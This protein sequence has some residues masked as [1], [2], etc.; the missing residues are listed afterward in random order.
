MKFESKYALGALVYLR[1]GDNR[2]SPWMVSSVRF[3]LS[4]GTIYQC[5]FGEL[6][7]DFCEKEIQSEPCYA[8]RA[9]G[10]S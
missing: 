3:S 8:L 4:G 10:G 9:G 6:C 1:T 7:A 5:T 2:E